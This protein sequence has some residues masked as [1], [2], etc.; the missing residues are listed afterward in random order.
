MSW[1]QESDALHARVRAFCATWGGSEGFDALA[2]AI[3]DYQRRNVP[4]FARLLAETSG[5]L[6]HVDSIPAVPADAFRLTR[7]AAHPA[8][9]DEVRFATSG[10]TGSDR[11]LH[12]LRTTTTYREVALAFGRRALLTSAKRLTVVALAPVLDTPPSSSLG[13]M[14]AAFMQEFDG[15]GLDGSAFAPHDPNRWLVRAEGIDLT[16]LDRACALATQRAEPLLLLATSFALVG[17]LDALGGAERALPPGSAVMQTG[18][19]KGRTREIAAR[20]LRTELARTFRIPEAAIVSEYGMTELSSQLYEGT[21]PGGALHAAAEIY[22]SPPWLRVAAVDPV[23]LAVRKPGEP[24]LARF[25][26]LANV[27]SAVAIVTRDRVR[28]VDGGIQLLGREAGAPPR[29]CSLSIE[30]LLAGAHDV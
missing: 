21:L 6:D 23:S 18:G 27:D 14:M 12:A 1:V 4:G 13:F 10:T 22:L 2:L 7:V 15:R 5:Q 25:V 30:A 3:A 20:E 24:G 26:D 28:E 9:V 17:L 19:F 29:G 11:G 16:G 8:D